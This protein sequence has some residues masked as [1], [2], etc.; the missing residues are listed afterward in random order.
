MYIVFVFFLERYF[1]SHYSQEPKTV[2]AQ[3]WQELSCISAHIKKRYIDCI[4]NQHSVPFIAYICILL[5]LFY[6]VFLAKFSR[7]ELNSAEIICQP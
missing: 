6:Y 1:V 4:Y 2:R 3:I 7:I 5:N